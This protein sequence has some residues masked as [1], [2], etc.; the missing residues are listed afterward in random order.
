MSLTRAQRHRLAASAAYKS[1]LQKRMT[2]REAQ[3]WLHPIRA[4][5]AQMLAGEADAIRGFAVTRLHSGDDYAR[6]DQ[7][8]A[9]FRCLLRRLMPDLDASPLLQVEIK[10]RRRQMLQP[11]E[12]LAC[13]PLFK[14]A[15]DRLIKC[16][17]ADVLA[18]A[19]TEQI[20]IEMEAMGLIKEAA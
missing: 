9:G 11:E 18:A 20:A 10:L 16:I 4:A 19:Q 6:T 2:R 8:I 15:E 5:F 14:T 1:G 3:A 13:I 17:K 12:L 7:C